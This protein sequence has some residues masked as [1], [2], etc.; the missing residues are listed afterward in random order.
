MS[1][2]IQKIKEV[3]EKLER[4]RAELKRIGHE[5]LPIISHAKHST[6]NTYNVYKGSVE[7]NRIAKAEYDKIKEIESDLLMY[8][9]LHIKRSED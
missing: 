2:E 7:I 5:S 6:L 9:M 4:V 8:A 3:V 1:E